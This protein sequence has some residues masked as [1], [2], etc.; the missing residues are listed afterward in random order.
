MNRITAIMK[1]FSY[2]VK[3]K[4]PFDLKGSEINIIVLYMTILLCALD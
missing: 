2:S 1:A 3:G 4:M